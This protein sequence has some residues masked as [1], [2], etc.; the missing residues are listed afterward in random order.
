MEVIT[1]KGR[2]LLLFRRGAGFVVQKGLGMD[3]LWILKVF[4]ALQIRFLSSVDVL[5]FEK[6]LKRND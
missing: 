6:A 1:I 4:V 2:I 3:R 5:V